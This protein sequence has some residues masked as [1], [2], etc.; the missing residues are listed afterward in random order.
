MKRGDRGLDNNLSTQGMRYS[1]VATAQLA[2]FAASGHAAH[3]AAWD[4]VLDSDDDND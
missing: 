2:A 3:A 4:A 1:D